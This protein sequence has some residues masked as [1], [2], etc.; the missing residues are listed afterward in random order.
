MCLLADEDGGTFPD[1]FRGGFLREE[2][3]SDVGSSSGLAA[4]PASFK[5]PKAAGRGIGVGA[6]PPRGI[7]AAHSGAEPVPG[8]VA[9]GRAKA[10]CQLSSGTGGFGL[11]RFGVRRWDSSKC[12]ADQRLHTSGVSTPTLMSS[13]SSGSANLNGHYC[14]AERQRLQRVC[15]VNSLSVHP[16]LNLRRDPTRDTPPPPPSPAGPEPHI[17]ALPR[18]WPGHAPTTRA[19][20]PFPASPTLAGVSGRSIAEPAGSSSP[21]ASLSSRGLFHRNMGVSH[22]RES[23]RERLLCSSRVH[24]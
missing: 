19:A 16:N 8:D 4:H 12:T 24:A 10:R 3:W 20:L 22:E 17:P 11:A 5:R 21:Q 15:W 18:A 23:E 1:V 2:T 7:A 13:C 14:M 9:L 6:V